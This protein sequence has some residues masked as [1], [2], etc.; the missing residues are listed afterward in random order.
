MSGGKGGS[1]TSSV[2][3]PDWIKEPMER[4]LARGE[5]AADLGYMPYYGP[6]VAAK[7]PE[8]GMANKMA[9]GRSSAL[10][11]D[12]SGMDPM[13]GL[14]QAQTYD[15]GIQGYSSGGLYDQAVA[16]LAARRPGQAQAYNDMFIDPQTGQMS[17]LNQ[18]SVTG[19]LVDKGVDPTLA[20]AI[21]SGDSDSITAA[22]TSLGMSG[23][24]I[25]NLRKLP[26]NPLMPGGIL[27]MVTNA[28]ADYYAGDYGKE[29]QPGVYGNDTFYRSGGT[30]TPV[31]GSDFYSS[32]EAS[33]NR[34]SVGTSGGGN[35]GAGGGNASRGFTTGGW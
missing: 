30:P 4:N 13:G 23:D 10:G 24:M 25:N 35:V 29:G 19:Q 20:R 17:Q 34:S 15:G 18:D 26:T 28:V 7:S 21:S 8:F 3:V 16:E 31:R 6:D 27:G 12:M 22:G 33:S 9:Y 1:T 5:A 14:P 32:S 2:E 11:Y